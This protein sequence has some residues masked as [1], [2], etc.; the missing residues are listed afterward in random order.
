MSE[1][2]VFPQ[3]ILESTE[4]SQ[5]ELPLLAAKM[6]RMKLRPTLVDCLIALKNHEVDPKTIEQAIINDARSNP[7]EQE[8]EKNQD[9]ENPQH[10]VEK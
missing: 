5:M 3:D 9:L 8:L 4:I 10:T 6:F 7:P 1:L 2:R